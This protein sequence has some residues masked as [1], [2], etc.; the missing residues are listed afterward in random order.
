MRTPDLFLAVALARRAEQRQP[1]VG[2]IARTM[3]VARVGSSF[4][5][6]LALPC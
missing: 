4:N 1:K 2:M 5:G 6:A 3:A